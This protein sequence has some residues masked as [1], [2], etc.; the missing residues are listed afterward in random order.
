MSIEASDLRR[1]QTVYHKN[2]VWVCIENLKVAKGKGQSYQTI[3]LKNVKTGQL[4]KER[5]RTTE[6]FEQAQVDKKTMTYLYSDGEGHVV[7][8]NESYEQ[9]HLPA[10]LI[11][12]QSVYLKEDIE[13]QVAFVEGAPVIVE[14]PNTVDLT[15][16]ETPPQIKGA[17]AT[18]Q[19]KEAICEGGAKIRVP[20][21]VNVGTVIRVDTRTNEYVSRA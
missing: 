12:D 11:G 15:V 2:G 7:M 1:G 21:F 3:Q 19:P 16:T 14:L 5:F 13:L 8:D 10:D 20:P 17:T 6:D 18:N 9:I 4:I